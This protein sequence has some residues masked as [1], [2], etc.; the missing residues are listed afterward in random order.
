MEYKRNDILKLCVKI[1]ENCLGKGEN[2]AN[3]H[4]IL[5]QQFIQKGRNHIK[6]AYRA[7]NKSLK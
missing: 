1:A 4:C 6:L 2:A 5:F 7:S 3:Q